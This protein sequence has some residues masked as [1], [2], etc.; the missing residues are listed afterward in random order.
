MPGYQKIIRMI[1]TSF[2][3]PEYS[4]HDHYT[5]KFAKKGERQL[6][7]VPDETPF[8]DKQKTGEIQSIVRALLYY[9]RSMDNTISPT[10]NEISMFQ[11]RP[12]E[13]I[14]KKLQDSLTMLPHSQM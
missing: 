6:T 8:L 10:L 4:P 1:K 14:L 11:S 2:T 12:T 3:K 9:G 13:N 5:I 7:T